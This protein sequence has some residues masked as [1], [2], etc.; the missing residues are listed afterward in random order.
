MAR[1]RILLE[2][3]QASVKVEDKE[4]VNVYVAVKLNV[5]VDVE[6]MVKVDD[7]VVRASPHRQVPASCAQCASSRW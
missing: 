1:R 6:V 7:P 3:D 5:G 4:R 2:N